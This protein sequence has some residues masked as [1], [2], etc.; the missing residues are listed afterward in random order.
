[1]A[2]P[3]KSYIT[4]IMTRVCRNPVKIDEKQPH[5]LKYSVDNGHIG[6]ELH[7]DQCDF[8]ANLMMSRS[9]SY[10]GGGTYFPDAKQVV[11]LEYGEFLVHPGRLLH[12]G[13]ELSQGVR[14]L[15]IIFADIKWR[16]SA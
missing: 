1:M 5:V 7:H 15:M 8:T 9:S 10:A 4:N 6:V 11:R 12:S 13:V 2:K 16:Y 3:I 14:Y